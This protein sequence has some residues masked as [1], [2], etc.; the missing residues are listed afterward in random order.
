ML[1]EDEPKTL[2]VGQLGILGGCA[3]WLIIATFC[4]LP[5]STTQS[6]VGATV[7][8]SVC[9][10]GLHG[11]QWMEIVKIISSWFISPLLSGLIS[12]ILYL[13]VDH[14]VLRKVNLN[15]LT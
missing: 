10:K 13:I 5:V 2:L 8:F 7:G 1:Y 12:T 11:I 14:T 3:A 15:K 4:E 9:L 6:V